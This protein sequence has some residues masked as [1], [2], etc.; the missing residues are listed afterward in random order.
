[1]RSTRLALL[2]G[3]IGVIGANSLSLSPMAGLIARAFAGIEAADVMVAAGVYGAS[4]AASALMLAPLADR[5][6]AGRTLAW[7][8]AGLAAALALTGAAPSLAVLVLGQALAGLAAGAALPSIYTLAAQIAPPGRE[9]ATLSLVLTGWTLSLV[10]GVSGAAALADAVH[11]RLVFVVLAAVAFIAALGVARV[12]PLSPA[13]GSGRRTSPLSALRVSGV[14]RV[15]VAVTAYMTAFYGTYSYVGAHLFEA[16]GLT[17][18]EIGLV[19]LAYGLGFGLAAPLGRVLDRIRPERAGPA[20]FLVLGLVYAAIGASAGNAH[21]VLGLALLWGAVNHLGLN[22]LVA[23][24]TALDP[25]QRGAIMGLYGA[26]T[27]AAVSVGALGFKPVFD[28]WGLAG[29]AALSAVLVA[30]ASSALV[31]ARRPGTV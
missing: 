23:R 9:S 20:A 5:I 8:L 27:Y 16:V 12:L 13:A 1:M 22:V 17:T 2:I 30:T 26:V 7:A 11:W 6:G 19:P 29:C 21:A 14:P 25:H 28:L 4:T 18:A 24:L 10:L 31:R 15:L 3:A